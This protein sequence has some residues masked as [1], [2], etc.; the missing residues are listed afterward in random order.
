VKPSLKNQVRAVVFAILLLLG[1]AIFFPASVNA[2]TTIIWSENFENGWGDWIATKGV[3][4]IGK[5]TYGTDAHKDSSCA[6]TVLNGKYPANSSSWLVSSEKKLPSLQQNEKLQLRFWHWFNIYGGDYG[7]VQVSVNGGGWKDISGQFWEYS[8]AW[9]Q[10][11]ADLSAYADS[12]ICIGFYFYSG[13]YDHSSGWYIDE[14]SIVKGRF[15]FQNPEGFELGIGDWYATKGVWDVGIPTKGPGK[16]HTGQNCAGT[17]LNGNY[18]ANSSSGLVSPEI[19]LIPLPNEIPKLH[20]YHWFNI[21]GGD[22]GQV[23]ISVNG[24]V[25]KD[26]SNKFYEYSGDWTPYSKTL[27]EYADST[28]RFIFYFYSTTYD[29]NSGW[30]VDDVIITGIQP[31][32]S[33]S[34]KVY[35]DSVSANAGTFVKIPVQISNVA[36]VAGAEIKVKYDPNILDSAR[37]D[38]ETLPQGFLAEDSVYNDK[39]AISI[40]GSTSLPYNTGTLVNIMFHVKE[41]AQPG[42]TCKLVLESVALFDDTSGSPNLITGYSTQNGL[43][44]VAGGLPPLIEIVV[45]P[46]SD[47]LTVNAARDFSAEAKYQDGTFGSISVMWKVENLFGSIG[48]INPTEG[49]GASFNATGPGD[50]LIIATH[51]SLQLSD[52]AIVVVGKTKG[53]INIDDVVNVPDAIL[54]LQII[55]V[56]FSPH[57]YQLWAADMNSDGEVNEGDALKILQERLKSLLP[58]LFVQSQIGPAIVKIGCCEQTADGMFHVPIS[59][60]QRNDVYASGFDIGYDPNVLT[61]V[62]VSAAVSSSLIMTNFDDAGLVRVSL[63]NTDGLLNSKGEILTLQFKAKEKIGDELNLVMREVRL[64]DWSAERIE[65]DVTNTFTPVEAM[66]TEFALQQNY[67]NPFNPTTTIKYGLPKAGAVT[68]KIY[69]MQGQEIRILVNEEVNEGT[70]QV[71]WDSYNN[72]GQPVPSGVYIYKLSVD[73]GAWESTKKMILIK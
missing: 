28:V 7:K 1:L 63:I 32:D 66:P 65:T 49:I 4:G 14:V 27:P 35:V 62:G 8:G 48:S 41:D 46:K 16:A 18:P 10:Y 71:V 60:Q 34:R 15:P 47:T 6:A 39:I 36:G 33:T 12:T 55:G 17:V 70:H 3:W 38:L 24:G 59:V 25:W 42:E 26:I 73:N 11:I 20:F 50:G 67:P 53:D 9:T 56:K 44:T 61:P 57:L 5:P 54:C 45:K 2:Q 72:T 68:L 22:Y 30:Y 31:P 23:K 69:N 43:F 37:V 40:A 21:Y 51:N 13:T 58:K 64:F 52:S 19:P 29:H